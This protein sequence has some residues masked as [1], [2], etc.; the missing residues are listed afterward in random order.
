MPV[1][2]DDIVIGDD[3]KVE[4]IPGPEN[5]YGLIPRDPEVHKV[6]YL[7]VAPPA[8]IKLIPWSELPERIK[9]MEGQKSR[10]S[11]VR[12]R[13]D[14]RGGVGKPIKSLYQD[15]IGYCW[16][17]GPVIGMMLL[18]AVNN[19]PYIRLNPF[20][21][22]CKIKNFRDEG[23]WGAL[24]L[25]YLVKYGCPTEELW[26]PWAQNNQRGMMSRSNDTPEAWADAAKNKVVGAWADLQSPAYDRNMSVQQI[27]TLLCNRT[28]VIGDFDYWSHCVAICDPVDVYPNRDPADPSRY[29]QRTW[30][31]W[32]DDWMNMGMAVFKDGKAWPN[33]AVAPMEIMASAS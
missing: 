31:S 19:L 6:G 24:S 3:F 21:V 26:K 7:S 12:M 13:G 33:N 17:F 27:L 30:N 29:G 25:D 22:G 10:L 5:G 11:D 9:D 16:V 32:G 23:G 14:N 8:Q 1:A 4:H 2:H 18:R 28:P 20:A 15:G